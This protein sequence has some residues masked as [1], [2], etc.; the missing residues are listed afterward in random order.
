MNN[1]KLRIYELAKELN[2]DSKKLLLI[3]EKLKIVVKSHT[4]TISEPDGRT[5]SFKRVSKL[6]AK[7]SKSKT[8]SEDWG[9][10]RL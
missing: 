9:Y 3:C 1:G 10:K 6:T 8:N 4:S 2:L 5:H 7:S